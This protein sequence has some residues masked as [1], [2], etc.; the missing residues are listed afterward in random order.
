[1]QQSKALWLLQRLCC[2][3]EGS[4]CFVPETAGLCRSAAQQLKDGGCLSPTSRGEA[5]KP[6]TPQGEI[7]LQVNCY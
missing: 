5:G 6:A 4:Q 7:H 3:F 2:S 1:M